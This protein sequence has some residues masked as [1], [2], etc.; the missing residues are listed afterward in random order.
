[1][2]PPAP[3]TQTVLPAIFLFSCIFVEFC[4]FCCLLDE[5]SLLGSLTDS[6]LH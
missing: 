3:V 6:E 2:K 1:M 4:E 5:S